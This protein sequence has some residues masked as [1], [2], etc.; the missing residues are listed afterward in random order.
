MKCSFIKI[1]SNQ[2]A[3]VCGRGPAELSSCKYCGRP[4]SRL[5]DQ[6]INN[7]TCDISMCSACSYSPVK[8]Y[9]LCYEHR[10]QISIGN[11]Y[12]G[13]RGDFIGR[14]SPLGNRFKLDPDKNR[15]DEE[16]KLHLYKQ[17]LWQQI[18][19]KTAAYQKLC[20]LRDRAVKG[21]KIRLICTC[22]PR[23]CHAEIVERAGLKA[24]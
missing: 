24:V 12:H 14:P 19:E 13:H 5:C 10:P 21:E 15:A 1:N 9:D 23:R 2:S 17:W 4:G 8:N 18:K 11:R 20:E 3:I 22:W 6:K 7:K 16:K